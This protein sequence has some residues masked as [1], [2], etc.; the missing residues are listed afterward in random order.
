VIVIAPAR[1]KY[2]ARGNKDKTPVHSSAHGSAPRLDPD[3]HTV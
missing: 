3:C 2:R 1:K